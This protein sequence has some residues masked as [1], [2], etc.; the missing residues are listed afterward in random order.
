MSW[1]KKLF[2]SFN[3]L[4]TFSLSFSLL[5]DSFI[6]LLKFLPLLHSLHSLS[7]TSPKYSSKM[8]LFS[9][10]L[11]LVLVFLFFVFLFLSFSFSFLSSRLSDSIVLS[12][13]TV[14]NK[15]LNK[16]NNSFCLGVGFFVLLFL[17]F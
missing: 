14:S 12:V 15:S 4:T 8:F 9:F 13:K 17:R 1:L 10:F 11:A 3:S 2:A 16:F 5:H 6:K 7:S